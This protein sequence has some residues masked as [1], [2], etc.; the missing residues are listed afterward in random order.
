MDAAGFSILDAVLDGGTSRIKPRRSVVTGFVPPQTDPEDFGEIAFNLTDRKLF[1]RDADGE[2]S[3]IIQGIAEHSTALTYAAGDFAVVGD[4]LYLCI[5][6]VPVPGPFVPANWRALTG[7]SAGLSGAVITAPGAAGRNRIV[8]AAAAAEGLIID[9]PPTQTADLLSIPG[10]AAS[11]TGK[12]AVDALGFPNKRFGASIWR[13]TQPTHAF[14]FRGQAAAFNGTSWVPANA[15]TPTGK[16]LA[17]VDEIID[18]NT[19]VLRS[20]G[21]IVDL[22][23]GAFAGGIITPGATYYVSDTVAGQLTT[24][25]PLTARVDPVL[26]AI[27]ATAGIVAVDNVA[28]TPP[29]STTVDPTPPANPTVGQLWYDTGP[30]DTLFVWVSDG[31]GSRWAPAVVIPTLPPATTVGVTPPASPQVGQLWFS[32]V[33]PVGLFVWH[34]SANGSRQWVQTS[35]GASA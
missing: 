32:T 25:K 23:T 12:L 2:A 28:P 10:T 33:A 35:S 5:T 17:L 1:I 15:A 11:D 20:A 14:T 6:P 26:I 18:A 31:S 22:Q 13:Q 21:R 19:L 3:Q 30:S 27:S 9:A 34:A 4:I 29:P 7:A 8:P 24:T 16:A